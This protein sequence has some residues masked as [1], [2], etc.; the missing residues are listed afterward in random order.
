MAGAGYAFWIGEAFNLTVGNDF[1]YAAFSGDKDKGEP[2]SGWF[3][4]V[5]LGFM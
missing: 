5:Y 2:V 1:H 3:D 4:N